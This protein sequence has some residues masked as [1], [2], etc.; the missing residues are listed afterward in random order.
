M[1]ISHANP[2]DNDFTLWLS[3]RLASAGYV[4]WSDLTKLIG[5]EI[6]WDEFADA[7]RNHSAKVVSVCS[8]TAFSKNGWKDELSLSLNVE[9]SKS[10]K[11]FVIPLRLDATPW[12]EFPVEIIRRNG[13]NFKGEWQSGLSQLLKKLDVDGVPR[14]ATVNATALSQ[15]ST[16]FLDMDG[17]LELRDETL[18]SNVIEIAK[19][20]EV[21]VVSRLLQGALSP[22]PNLMRWPAE[23]KRHLAYSFAHLDQLEDGVFAPESQLLL[24]DF[25]TQGDPK[26]GLLKQDAFNIVANLLRQQINKAV[27][28]RGLVAY[29]FANGRIGHFVAA[30]DAKVSPRVRFTNPWGTSESRS[31]NGYSP[32]NKVFWHF[33]PEISLRVGPT[34]SASLHSH[35]VFTEDGCRPIDDVKRVHRLRRR[36]CKNWWQDR[37]RGMT[38]AYL[39]YLSRGEDFVD[40]P[41]SDSVIMLLGLTPSPFVCPVT[42]S[43]PVSI[44]DELLE[45]NAADTDDDDWDEEDDEEDSDFQ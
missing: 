23:I 20:P 25:L 15:W 39:T 13:I 19:P 41:L 8:A 36:F 16:S 2:Q 17:D 27:E 22:Q 11:D 14:S 3:S 28:R 32:K 29:E 21:I 26:R 9:R 1:F 7:I 5:G 18:I 42:A 43:S 6:H 30:Q 24:S 44:T 12:C 33:A 31:L 38:L 45:D 4:V 37:W 35:V 34:L 10:L 40:V